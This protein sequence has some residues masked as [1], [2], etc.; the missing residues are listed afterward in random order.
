MPARGCT[1]RWS[2]ASSCRRLG[3]ETRAATLMSKANTQV[4]ADIQSALK[5]LT[6]TGRGAM[7]ALFKVLGVSHPDIKTLPG[8]SEAPPVDAAAPEAVA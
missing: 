2:R 1:V 7:G 6:G 8:L 4:S 5:R 3:I